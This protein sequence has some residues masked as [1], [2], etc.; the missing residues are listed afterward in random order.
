MFFCISEV[1]VDPVKSLGDTG[2][3]WADFQS[4]LHSVDCAGET[5]DLVLVLTQSGF[6]LDLCV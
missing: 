2:N 4:V 5:F 3:F 6:R 1:W